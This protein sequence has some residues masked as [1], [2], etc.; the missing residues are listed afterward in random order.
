[1]TVFNLPD[2]R[3][4]STS[5]LTLDALLVTVDDNNNSPGDTGNDNGGNDGG[6]GS[7]SGGLFIH[8]LHLF[9]FDIL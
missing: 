1:M 3:F 2:N 5:E 8:F 7:V 6:G 9:Q 4:E